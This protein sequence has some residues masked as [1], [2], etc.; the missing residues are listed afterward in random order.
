MRL[1]LNSVPPLIKQTICKKGERR[2]RII[3]VGHEKPQITVTIAASAAG[4][5]VEPTQL[6]F[7][8]KTDRL[9]PDKGK[10]KAD[11]SQYFTHS[12]SH[13]QIMVI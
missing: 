7:G 3:G 8:E 10:I 4:S 5:I 6:V 12:S 9:H 11:E 13:W 2:V 1:T